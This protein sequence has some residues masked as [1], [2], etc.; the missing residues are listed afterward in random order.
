MPGWF[1]VFALMGAWVEDRARR[2]P[3]LAPLGVRVRG[4]ARRA[5]PRSCP[6]RS[7]PAGR[8]GFSSVRARRDATLEAFAWSDLRDA[9]ALRPAPAFVLAAKWSDAGKIALALGPEVAG[10]RDLRRSARLG[11]RR[12]RRRSRRP[13]R[14]PDRP[15]V[16]ARARRSRGRAAGPFARVRRRICARRATANRRSTLRSSRST[17]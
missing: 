15:G 9:P 13:G 11:F 6:S 2:R 1:F 4:P 14:R 5:R 16:R 3:D 8:C 17:A 12:R 7:R 10:V